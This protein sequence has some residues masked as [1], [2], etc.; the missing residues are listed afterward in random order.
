MA[1]DGIVDGIVS[2]CSVGVNGLSYLSVK[3]RFRLI[4]FTHAV[5][6]QYSQFINSEATAAETTAAPVVDCRYLSDPLDPE[7]LAEACRFGNEIVPDGKGTKD[8][9]K[10]SWPSE[11]IHL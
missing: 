5:P 9:V 1:Q 10:G 6:T 3:P 7:V 11:A 4:H 8:V 2:V